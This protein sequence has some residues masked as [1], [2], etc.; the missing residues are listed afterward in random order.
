MKE[1]HKLNLSK[2]ILKTKPKLQGTQERKNPT[3]NY[4]RETEDKQKK[5]NLNKKELKKNR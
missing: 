2:E 1:Q 5:Q 4:F 3:G